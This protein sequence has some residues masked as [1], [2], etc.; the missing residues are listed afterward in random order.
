MGVETLIYYLHCASSLI[1]VH[2]YDMEC[3]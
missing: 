2:T 3:G 1:E